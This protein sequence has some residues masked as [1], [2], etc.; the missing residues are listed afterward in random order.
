MRRHHV[1]VS[2]KTWP[3]RTALS[4][5]C[6]LTCQ[7]HPFA[8]SASLSHCFAPTSSQLDQVPLPRQVMRR[9]FCAAHGASK[10]PSPSPSIGR[11]CIQDSAVPCQKDVDMVNT[12]R[13]VSSRTRA[14]AWH[15]GLQ[16]Q[17]NCSSQV[18]HCRGFHSSRVSQKKINGQRHF[19]LKSPR[20]LGHQNLQFRTA[21]LDVHH[22]Q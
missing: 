12:K 18:R 10:R 11:L 15:P 5:L 7:Q 9:A 19:S 14:V 17:V 2:C 21:L 13:H 22:V 16:L 6:I 20:G 3:F 4:G 1:C 8:R